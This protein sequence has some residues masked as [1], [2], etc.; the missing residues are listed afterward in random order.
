MKKDCFYKSVL[1]FGLFLLLGGCSQQPEDVI[2][3]YF[4]A[5]KWEDKLST[6]LDPERTKPLMERYYRDINVTNTGIEAMIRLDGEA[7]VNVGEYVK[8]K[9]RYGN[10]TRVYYV[11]RSEK[12]GYKINWQASLG[13]N[14]MPRN[15]YTAQRSMEPMQFRVTATLSD[16]YGHEFKNKRMWYWS[17]NLSN[18]LYGYVRKDSKIGRRMYELLQ[19]GQN[20]NLMVKIRFISETG[21]GNAVVIED[22]ISED[23]LE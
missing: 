21:Y 10:R 18:W 14:E 7:E 1:F 5:K 6:V 2:E 13:I 4:A 8:L 3:D 11:K 15:V 22:I 16:Y 23:W 12:N 17:I 9:V 20:H 19:D